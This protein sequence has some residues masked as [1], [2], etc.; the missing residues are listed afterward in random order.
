M[1]TTRLTTSSSPV[2]T[3]GNPFSN[4]VLPNTLTECVT[5]ILCLTSS[6]AAHLVAIPFAFGLFFL[7]MAR[8]AFGLTKPST[9]FR[10]IV[11]TGASSGIGEAFAKLAAQRAGR[12]GTVSVSQTENQLF[13]QCVHQ[14][15][16]YLCPTV[17]GR[18]LL[19]GRNERRLADVA[20]ACRS[21]GGV[22]EYRVLD[23][24]TSQSEAQLRSVLED[25]DDR[26]QVDLVFC[27]A[28]VA[29]TNLSTPAKSTGGRAFSTLFEEVCGT[30]IQGT[31][32]TMAPLMD[33][34][35]ARRS[36]TILLNSSVNAFF[37][38]P[39]FAWY[40]ATKATLRSAA[41]DLRYVLAPFNVHVAA[42][43]PGFIDTR[44]T[45][46]LQSHLG[47]DSTFPRALFA[48]PEAIAQTTLNAVEDHQMD[49]F[50]PLAE[51]VPVYVTASMP[52]LIQ[53][54]ATAVAGKMRPGGSVLT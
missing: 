17:S 32:R 7:T 16:Q 22:A 3:A 47:G 1:D 25:F 41:R 53:N 14:A 19:I 5:T 21:F 30:N 50:Y 8:E 43:Y 26:N 29:T 36:G 11:V 27:N 20:N 33:R 13:A 6:A 18:L 38:P 44:M 34:F 46:P 35:I 4:L 52:P 39:S 28:G 9:H 37:G 42:L 23:I 10:S 15:D 24:G 51:F 54:I 12:E 2:K 45:A 48:S 49:I 31:F 40:N